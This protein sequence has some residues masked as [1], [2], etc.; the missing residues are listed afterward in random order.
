MGAC[1]FCGQDAGFL[2]NAHP[3]CQ[4]K[5]ASG[6]AK[7]EKLATACATDQSDLFDAKKK[8]AAVAMGAFITPA[9][10]KSLLIHAWEQAVRLALC[11]SLVSQAQEDRL[12]NYKNFFGLEQEDLDDHGVFTALIKAG[13]LRELSEG[14][15]PNRIMEAG[16]LPS[17]FQKDETLVWLFKEVRYF[18]PLINTRNS[19]GNPAG[20]PGPGIDL[21]KGVYYP[22]GSFTGRPV[23][24]LLNLW[25]DIGFLGISNKNLYFSGKSQSFRLEFSRIGLFS[26]YDDGIAIRQAAPNANPQ[27]FKTGDG[28]F[29]YNLLMSLAKNS[30]LVPPAPPANYF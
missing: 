20:Y 5:H 4:E 17:N 15:L 2:K 26:A 18:E 10:L 11:N 30:S 23:G 1:K 27:I 22:A 16:N 7:I 25:I 24:F 28:W 8:I 13:I 14:K 3:A 6:C 21:P 9:I 29:T 19:S 12:V